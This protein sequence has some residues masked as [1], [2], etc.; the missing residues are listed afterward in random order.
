MQAGVLRRLRPSLRPSLCS[1][2]RPSRTLSTSAAPSSDP[3][4]E[5]NEALRREVASLRQQLGQTE[6][7]QPG[8][9]S[10]FAG[11]DEADYT[12]KPHFYY[13][14]V[15]SPPPVMP[16]FR[17]VDD[18][19]RVVD[20][21]AAA[22]L[23]DISREFALALM[24]SM[25]RVNEFDKIFL[26]AQRQG[27]IAFY[28][29]GRGEEGCIIG[30]AAALQ[31]EDWCL[32][33]YRELGAFFWRGWTFQQV[34]DQLSSTER[35][36]AHGRQLPLHIGSY[37][38]RVVYISSTLGTQCPHAAGVAYFEK[39]K[40][41]PNVALAYFGEGCASHGDIPSA[42]NIAAVHGAPTIFFCR[43]NGYAIS[44]PT[45]EQYASDG[46]A[47]RGPAYG[48]PSIRVDG[49][50]VLATLVATRRAREIGL[51]EGKPTLIEAMTYRMG[52]HST[53]DD[54]SKY[55]NPISPE[56]GWSS[57][58]AYWEARSP[59]IR[60]GRYLQSQGWWNVQME[61]QVRTAARKE[62]IKSLNI[63]NESLRPVVDTLF[64]DVY[65]DLP[66]SLKEQ[67]AELH[68]HMDRYP[69]A[70]ADVRRA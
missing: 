33:Q 66:W 39:L 41:E 17:L 69:Q 25:L 4:A 31:P 58:R 67:Q 9:R 27:R 42:L 45:R 7:A 19:G 34:A 13:P 43:N 15:D 30:S 24:V 49:N 37:K 63:A 64:T 50:D 32:P 52:A 18:L 5:E 14:R 26:D 53:S 60:F 8:D 12:S 70:Y 55:R 57:E 40:K 46:I 51:R 62:A 65:D 10:K 38:K 47:Q 44:T 35:D 54:D 11:I 59:I 1:S 21:E 36:P 16:I 56:D 20:D 48:L 6:P 22:Y 61:E 68:E 29:T 2:L 23:P 28:L 3:L